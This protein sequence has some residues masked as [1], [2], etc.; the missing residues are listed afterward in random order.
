M[1]KEHFTEEQM[2]AVIREVDREAVSVVAKRHS[3]STKS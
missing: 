1:C 3:H 2:G